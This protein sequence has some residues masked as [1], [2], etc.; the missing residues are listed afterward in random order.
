M[1]KD[2]PSENVKKTLRGFFSSLVVALIYITHLVILFYPPSTLL[3]TIILLIIILTE[4]LLL[5]IIYFSYKILTPNE[6]I[7]KNTGKTRIFLKGYLW[8]VL[9]NTALQIS[10]AS[11]LVVLASNII[12]ESE[13]VSNIVYLI[14]I[15]SSFTLAPLIIYL[16]VWILMLYIAVKE[17]TGYLQLKQVL[18]ITAILMLSSMAGYMIYLTAGI[19]I[20]IAALIFQA[21]WFLEASKTIDKTDREPVKKV[22]KTIRHKRLRKS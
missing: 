5:F 16:V 7:F 1:L 3:T 4:A 6:Y 13:T 18:T 19:I 15:L 2:E 11:L 21:Y 10:R 20:M 12:G 9:I 8:Y 14:N 22:K 17:F